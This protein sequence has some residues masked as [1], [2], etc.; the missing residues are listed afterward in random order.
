MGGEDGMVIEKKAVSEI[1]EGLIVLW[2]YKMRSYYCELSFDVYT[3]TKAIGFYLGSLGIYE[4][5]L[6]KIVEDVAKENELVVIGYDEIKHGDVLLI[7]KLAF[8]KDARY[9]IDDTGEKIDIE[10]KEEIEETLKMLC[11]GA[12]ELYRRFAK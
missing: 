2:N 3:E 4:G 11:N 6:R 5:P 12:E 1:I 8:F 9:Q 7:A 10:N